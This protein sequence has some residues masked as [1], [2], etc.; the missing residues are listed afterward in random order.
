[1]VFGAKIVQQVI[2]VAKTWYLLLFVNVVQKVKAKLILDKRRASNAAPANSMMLKVPRN[3]Y[4]VLRTRITF[5]LKEHLR[6]NIAPTGGLHRRTVLNAKR[7]VQEHLV[8]LLV[9]IAKI[10]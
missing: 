6:A 8:L 3:V 1:M 2:T 4:R 10:A 7:V 9:K 5:P